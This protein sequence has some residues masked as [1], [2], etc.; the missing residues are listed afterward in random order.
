MG[1]GGGGQ[2]V[3]ERERCCRRLER[4][5]VGHVCWVDGIGGFGRRIEMSSAQMFR[6]SQE[7]GE[8]ADLEGKRTRRGGKEGQARRGA[9]LTRAGKPEGMGGEGAKKGSAERPVQ[10][11]AAIAPIA[12]GFWEGTRAEGRNHHLA[13]KNPCVPR[14]HSQRTDA[15][16]SRGAE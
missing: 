9:K 1:V 13:P 7:S 14:H 12:P 3:Y 8:I 4:P 5:P 2:G 15:R 6:F 10:W 11:R 16:H